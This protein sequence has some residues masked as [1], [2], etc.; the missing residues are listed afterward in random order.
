MCCAPR[1]LDEKVSSLLKRKVEAVSC[2]D[3]LG[4]LQDA[5]RDP[6]STPK[7]S[8]ESAMGQHTLCALLPPQKEAI[9]ERVPQLIQRP[10]SRQ[11]DLI[12]LLPESSCLQ[13]LGPAHP[14]HTQTL[15][16]VIPIYGANIHLSSTQ[17]T[18]S[19]A[20]P[21][22]HS[23][24]PICQ[25]YSHLS[26]CSCSLVNGGLHSVRSQEQEAHLSSGACALHAERCQVPS[27]ALPV[28]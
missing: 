26:F 10:S 21:G 18:L 14:C 6:H 8:W 5:R 24:D 7:A 2:D 17:T 3:C 15:H 12:P 4:G 28:K 9:G 20:P 16:Y 19:K 25:T 1:A 13:E 23:W 11:G 27:P 22:K